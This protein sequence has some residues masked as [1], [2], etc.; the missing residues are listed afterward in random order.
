MF[1]AIEGSE[2]SGPAA[3]LTILQLT[4]G[5]VAIVVQCLPG[6]H[7]DA[8]FAHSMKFFRDLEWRHPWLRDPFVEWDS[9]QHAHVPGSSQLHDALRRLTGNLCPA[10][11]SKVLALNDYIRGV[12]VGTNELARKRASHLALLLTA[13]VRGQPLLTLANS[14][15]LRRD[16]A[17][18]FAC[19]ESA[20]EQVSLALGAEGVDFSY[21]GVL[22]RDDTQ[23]RPSK[24]PRLR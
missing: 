9:G 17:Q 1:A 19:L 20:T 14:A 12:G 2:A 16:Y 11:H 13:M 7:G 21:V 18:L 5:P 10:G 6:F 3:T 22:D 23:P 24:A 15:D 4:T 8:P